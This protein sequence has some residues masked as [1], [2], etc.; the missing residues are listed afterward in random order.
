M[1]KIGFWESLFHDIGWHEREKL[2]EAAESIGRLSDEAGGNREHIRSLYNL[3]RAQAEE[4][5]QL[6]TIL[7]VM[8]EILID[9]GV[10]SR[11]SLEARLDSALRKVE[12][13]PTNISGGPYRGETRAKKKSRPL[14]QPKTTCARCQQEVLWIHTEAREEGSVCVSCLE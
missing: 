13:E 12:D 6:R 11:E 10:V 7:R 3:D 2:N 1:E 8:G 5:E 4:L 14:R 9:N